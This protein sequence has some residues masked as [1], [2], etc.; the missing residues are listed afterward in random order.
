MR[1]LSAICALAALVACGGD[2][3]P[4]TAP[5]S[6][7]PPPP[8]A[9]LNWTIGGVVTDTLSSQPVAGATLAFSSGANL[10]SSES[11]GWELQG[12]GGSVNPTVTLSAAGYI[13][14]E[15]TIRWDSTGRADVRLDMVAD[16]APF[17]LD[18]FRQFVRNGMEEP[19]NLRALRRWVRTPNFYLDTRNP[20]TGGTLLAS[21]IADIGLAIREAVPQLTGG[22]FSAGTIDAAPAPF[23]RRADF[24]EVVIVDEPEGDF[25][26]DALVGAN[27][28][29][30]RINYARCPSPCGAFAPETVAH[31]VGHAMG[32]W[33]T[34]GNGI[35]N[36]DRTR[37][38]NN[39]QFSELERLHARV[40]Y[41]RPNGNMDP[42][43]DPSTFLSIETG[44]P[45][46]V[47]CKH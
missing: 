17:S 14:R 47:V 21:E 16:R 5:T 15:T 38:C 27:P 43:R 20:K 34:N 36:T 18:F 6:Q 31:E 30:I 4:A 12:T 33:H 25:C 35:M 37:M 28:G 23:V 29:R 3:R 7:A 9:P 40:A 45:T 13:T 8:A 39:R 1:H 24:I 46:R 44:H 42:D 22:Q 10:S 2:S 19:D 11:G 26:A 32:F 41:S